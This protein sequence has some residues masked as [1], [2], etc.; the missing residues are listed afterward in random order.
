MNDFREIYFEN[1]QGHGLFIKI[2][3]FVLKTDISVNEDWLQLK[4]KNGHNA[5]PLRGG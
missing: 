3:L 4:T 5:I 1:K 2:P